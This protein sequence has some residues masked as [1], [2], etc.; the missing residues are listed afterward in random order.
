MQTYRG[1]EEESEEQKERVRRK[2]ELMSLIR[3]VITAFIVAMLIKN[4][5]IIN[6]LITSGSMENTIMTDSRLIGFRLSYLFTEPQRGDIVLFR[7]PDDE[8]QTFVKRIIG[9]PGDEIEIKDGAVYINGNS[10]P[11]EEPY[12]REEPVGS[13]GVFEVPEEC[14][15]MMGDN[16]N[17][18]LDSRF[19]RNKYVN[20]EDIIGRALWVYW[21]EPDLLK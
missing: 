8:S 15:F 16:R 10:D 3:L 18:S 4:F 1:L 19:W 12:L 17:D 11:I 9:M 7:Y 21:P 6:A 20:E 2:K 13:Y 14:Y 5:V